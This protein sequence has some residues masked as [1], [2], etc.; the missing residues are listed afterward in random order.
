MRPAGSRKEKR[1]TGIGIEHLIPLLQADLSDVNS[2]VKSGVVHQDINSA[3]VFGSL[4]R[5][6]INATL[7]AHIAADGPG[8]TAKLTQIGDGVVGLGAGF[9]VGYDDTSSR[10]GKPKRNLAAD[11]P[12]GPGDE[13]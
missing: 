11:A 7:V 9:Q 1:P 10:A 8:G 6:G 3:H 12:G 4:A 5:R 13:H 2:F